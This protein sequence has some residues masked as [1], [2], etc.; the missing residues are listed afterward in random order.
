MALSLCACKLTGL[1]S[2]SQSHSSPLPC[3]GM[4]AS[5]SHAYCAQY[6]LCATQTWFVKLAQARNACVHTNKM[7]WTLKSRT[8]PR[9]PSVNPLK[10]TTDTY[11]PTDCRQ[12]RVKQMQPNV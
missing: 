6:E 4:A 10:K 8:R 11:R 5:T 9:P 12:S 2:Y 7:N 1:L 3:L